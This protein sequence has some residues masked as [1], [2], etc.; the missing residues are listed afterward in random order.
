M[1][2]TS[3]V[4][5]FI[6][7]LLAAM[8]LA[9]PGVQVEAAWPGPDVTDNETLFIGEAVTDWTSDI[10]TMVVGRQPRQESYTVTV[11]V[12]V[13]KPGALR[14]AS[15]GEARTRAIEIVNAVDSF[16][17]DD[18]DLTVPISWARITSRGATLVPFGSG[19]ACQA[20]AEIEVEARLT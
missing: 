18:P 5:A 13:A 6:D 11:E 19:W 9:L 10:P 3:T 17:A 1:P 16:L 15:A 20:T 12:W 2:T 14:A 7:A 4:P 8:K